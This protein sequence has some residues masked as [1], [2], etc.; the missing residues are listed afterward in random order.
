MLLA[1]KI[2]PEISML[3]PD[4]TRRSVRN[5]SISARNVELRLSLT[6]LL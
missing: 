3:S 2:A 5:D 6:Y 4:I 1:I